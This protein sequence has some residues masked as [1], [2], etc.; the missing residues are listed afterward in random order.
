MVLHH[1]LCMGIRLCCKGGVLELVRVWYTLNEC[2]RMCV[3]LFCPD[4]K[5]VV[6]VTCFVV[7]S[8]GLG[9]LIDVL[10]S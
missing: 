6:V 10:I 7:L 2:V 9:E 1:E 4:L 5:H 3:V 8:F